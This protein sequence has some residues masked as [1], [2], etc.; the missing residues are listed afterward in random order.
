MVWNSGI[1]AVTIVALRRA[2]CRLG[3]NDLRSAMEVTL[4]GAMEGTLKGAERTV[5]KRALFSIVIHVDAP[6]L[7]SET[8]EGELGPKRQLVCV[9]TSPGKEKRKTS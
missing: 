2:I 6:V 9:T 5:L 3:R 4:K 8:R 1:L 7:G